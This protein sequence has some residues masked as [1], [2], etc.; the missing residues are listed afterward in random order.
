[1]KNSK[2]NIA[3]DHAGFELKEKIKIYL[4]AEG[5][6]VADFGCHSADSM[7]YPDVVHPLCKQVL[8]EN[9][10]GILICGSAN[11]VSITANKYPNIRAAIAWKE[12]LAALARQHNDANIISLPA[13]FISE[14]EAKKIVYAFLHTN[15]E[16]GRHQ[17]R[18]DKINL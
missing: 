9:G 1:M 3:A 12:E 17:K 16:G 15:F 2:I 14:D 6:E 13:R 10:R 5:F 4:A 11:G 18:V 7:D 8:V